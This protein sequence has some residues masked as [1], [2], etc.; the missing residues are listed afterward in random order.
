MM[1]CGG[2][3][4][5][6]ETPEEKTPRNVLVLSKGTTISFPDGPMRTIPGPLKGNLLSFNYLMVEGLDLHFTVSELKRNEKTC[7]EQMEDQEEIGKAKRAINKEQLAKL[8]IWR[9]ERECDFHDFCLYDEMAQRNPAA[10][11]AGKP[12]MENLVYSLCVGEHYIIVTGL[13][14]PPGTPVDD[15][16]R[17][18]VKDV[19]L[20]IKVLPGEESSSPAAKKPAAKPSPNPYSTKHLSTTLE[21]GEERPP[22]PAGEPAVK[23]PTPADNPNPEEHRDRVLE[24]AKKYLKIACDRGDMAA[25]KALLRP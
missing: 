21:N 19:V 14:T 1:A 23:P 22:Q 24:R 15:N 16:A 10:A 25:C 5:S 12:H 11:R 3:K 4:S 9:T 2:Q 20:S 18:L 6:P 13:L 8:Q 7:K 17:K